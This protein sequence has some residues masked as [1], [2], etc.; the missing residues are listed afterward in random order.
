MTV[1]EARTH[2]FVTSDVYFLIWL[3]LAGGGGVRRHL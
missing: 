2:S 1:T 3:V